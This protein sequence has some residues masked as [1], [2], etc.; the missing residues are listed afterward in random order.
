MSRKHEIEVLGRGVLVKSGQLLVCH[1]KG[2]PHTYLPGGHVEFNEKARVALEREMME[3]M[4]LKMRA[5]AFLG[6]VEHSFMQ[7]SRLHCEIN[8]VFEMTCR[9]LKVDAHPPSM[10]DYIEFQWLPLATLARSNLEPYP[11]KRLIPA[12]LARKPGV[13]MWSGTY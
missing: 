5:T 7:K 1:S 9:D 2:K 8:L 11:L 10:E 4:G 12:W 13:E 6:G 3:E